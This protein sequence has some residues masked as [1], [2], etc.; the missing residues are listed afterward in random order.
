MNFT[1]ST[2]SFVE[3]TDQ[4]QAPKTEVYA[5]DEAAL[6]YHHLIYEANIVKA[7]SVDDEYTSITG[8]IG[9]HYYVQRRVPTERL[10]KKSPQNLRLQASLKAAHPHLS[11][12]GP[13]Q[14]GSGQV[15]SWGGLGISVK[16]TG[17]KRLQEQV[18]K[19]VYP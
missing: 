11:G 12:R 10:L 7:T 5:I 16:K 4:A 3:E 8:A 18:I 13:G 6:C 15:K 2:M 1:I 19:L 17:R 9:P 14:A